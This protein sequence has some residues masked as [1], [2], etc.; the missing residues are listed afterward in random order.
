MAEALGISFDVGV[1]VFVFLVQDYMLLI[2]NIM[3]SK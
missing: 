3:D 2:K 1:S